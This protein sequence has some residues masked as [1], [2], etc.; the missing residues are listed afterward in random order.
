MS[1][2]HIY[3]NKKVNVFILFISRITALLNVKKKRSGKKMRIGMLT[4]HYR[5]E[6]KKK[7][8]KQGKKARS[9]TPKLRQR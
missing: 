1:P 2:S 8:R 5:V 9:P 6:K 4:E 7:K 3:Y